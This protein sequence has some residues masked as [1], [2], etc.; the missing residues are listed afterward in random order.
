VVTLDPE[1]NGSGTTGSGTAVGN[2]S[3]GE[4]TFL[5]G[6]TRVRGSEFNDIITGN[7]A[8]N[9]LEGQGGNDVLTGKGGNDTLTGGTGAD[10]FAFGPGSGAD[11]ITDFHDSEG[12]RLDLRGYNLSQSAITNFFLNNVQLTNGNADTLITL[13]G[14]GNTILLSG[15]HSGEFGYNDIIFNSPCHRFLGCRHRAGPGRL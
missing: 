10:I 9:I 4:D 3:V 13:P 7:G 11:T 1:T 2:D 15:V 5:S 14:T 6:V 12:D 8:A